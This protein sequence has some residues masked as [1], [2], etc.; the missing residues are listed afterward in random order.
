MGGGAGIDNVV[1]SG[2]ELMY[3]FSG[4]EEIEEWVKRHGGWPFLVWLLV[5]L[6]LLFLT[7]WIN[8]EC[9]TRESWRYMLVAGVSVVAG[10]IPV[11]IKRRQD[12]GKGKGKQW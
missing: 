1:V 9:G 10:I 8:E 12:S 5:T 6:A 2:E 11:M 7:V 3:Y 4:I